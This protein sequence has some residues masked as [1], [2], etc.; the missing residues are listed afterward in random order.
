MHRSVADEQRILTL[1]LPSLLFR[2]FGSIL[3]PIILILVS[4][5]T[6]L[7]PFGSLIVI[8]VAIAG[9]TTMSPCM[10]NRAMAL[11]L[12]GVAF[13]FS[14]SL[15]TRLVYLKSKSELEVEKK[16]PA[17]EE[18]NSLHSETRQT[19]AAAN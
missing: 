13:N 1:G 6:Q 8:A 19:L 10:G 12:C 5:L 4:S 11:A 18:M 14:F 7:V 15:L 9:Y 16:K 2:A 3:G 17:K